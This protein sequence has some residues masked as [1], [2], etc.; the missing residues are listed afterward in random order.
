MTTDKTTREGAP[1]M[2]MQEIARRILYQR[3]HRFTDSG[4]DLSPF[5]TAKY[6]RDGGRLRVGF[7]NLAPGRAHDAVAR[8]QRYT[9]QRNMQLEWVVVPQLP[10][11]YELP[12]ALAAS[13]FRCIESLLLM[14]HVGL[15]PTALNPAVS[16]S[17]IGSF[18]TMWEY[19]YG[20]R[21]SFFDDPEPA[22]NV[23]TQR[24]RDRWREQEHGWCRYY[25]ATLDGRM[26]GGCYVSLW[27]DVPTLMGVYTLASARGRGVATAL[28]AHTIAELVH[29]GRDT[30]C[31]FVKVG[32]PAERLYRELGFLGL[33]N[34]D[35]YIWEPGY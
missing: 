9:A 29:R 13:R 28:V 3:M 4:P 26:A 19:E 22:H 5:A 6:R 7:T 24:A 18:Q 32:N 12:S 8:A 27:E 14:V 34:E 25:A 1:P 20:S 2:D 31:L 21:Q 23:V 16:V 30:C 15:V 11:E 33:F 10:G 35:M 17:Q